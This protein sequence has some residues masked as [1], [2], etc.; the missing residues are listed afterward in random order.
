MADLLKLTTTLPQD[1]LDGNLTDA[2]KQRWG[3]YIAQFKATLYT[4]LT[5]SGTQ[6][7]LLEQLCQVVTPAAS[8]ATGAFLTAAQLALTN[9]NLNYKAGT[10]LSGTLRAEIEFPAYVP[11]GDWTIARIRLR[12]YA[13]N[14]TILVVRKKIDAIRL[15]AA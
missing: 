15:E 3:T 9:A 13:G 4:H 14:F 5:R 11:S 6:C 8:L 2:G 1:P 10:I 7:T 12:D